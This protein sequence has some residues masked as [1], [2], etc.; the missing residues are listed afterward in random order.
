M[1]I[2]R[3]GGPQKSAS[4]KESIGEYECRR[5]GVS[6]EG[7]GFS[8]QKSLCKGGMDIFIQIGDTWTGGGW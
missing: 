6:W 4:L 1:K 3:R 8:T 7:E 5:V 2:P